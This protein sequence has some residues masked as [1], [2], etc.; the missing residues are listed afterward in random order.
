MILPR[1]C[2]YVSICLTHVLPFSLAFAGIHS[3]WGFTHCCCFDASVDYA[4]ASDLFVNDSAVAFLSGEPSLAHTPPSFGSIQKPGP[5]GI[6]PPPKGL[7]G[8]KKPSLSRETTLD[9]KREWSGLTQASSWNVKGEDLDMVSEDFP[10]ERTHRMIHGVEPEVVARRITDT[11]RSHSIEAEFDCQ[12]AK[13]KCKTADYV[14]FRIRLL[15]GGEN[16]DPVVVEV[17]RRCGATSSFM[18][19]CRAILNA[20]EGRNESQVDL[21]GSVPPNLKPVG[22]M[23]CLQHVLANEQKRSE[24][25]RTAI[26]DV[27]RMLKTTNRDTNILALE[28]LV[29]LTDPIKTCATASMQVSKCLVLGDGKHDIREDLVTMAERDV[30]DEDDE[31]SMHYD[32]LRTLALSAFANALTSCSKDGCLAS[33]LPQQSWLWD[34]LV[35]C[36]T[37][38]LKLA[39]TSATTACSAAACLH[40]ILG[41]SADARQQLLTQGIKHDLEAACSVG[42]ATHAMLFD[43]AA[44]CLKLC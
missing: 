11:L 27:A 5:V 29:S 42:K 41:C 3:S 7:K 12:K 35:P 16:C 18:K 24:S 33:S 21:P 32:Q 23:K 30:F 10:L 34:S 26:E 17:Q 44:R 8:L 13:A 36:L 39:S 25:S 38:E 22:Q 2:A 40:C 20:A 4:I 1:H 28:N 19:S 6:G 15:A 31:L 14:S 37:R 43:E 9:V